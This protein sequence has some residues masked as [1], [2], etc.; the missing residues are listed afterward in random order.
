MLDLNRL[1]KWMLN[2]VMVIYLFCNFCNFEYLRCDNFCYDH[3]WHLH[4]LFVRGCRCCD[5]M[6][7]GFTTTYAI[8]SYHHLCCEFESCSLRGVQHNVIKFVSDLWWFSIGTLVS[9]TDKLTATI[10]LK[11]CLTPWNQPN[12]QPTV[13]FKTVP[14][15][16]LQI[17]TL[18]EIWI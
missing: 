6:V 12:Q 1:R 3:I 5:H 16:T 13:C 11:Y 8:W 14:L 18:S 9:S 7:L 4:S 10:K 15:T 2:M 17:K